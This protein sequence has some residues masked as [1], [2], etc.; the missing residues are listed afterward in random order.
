MPPVRS[1]INQ[2]PGV[3]AHLHSYWQGERGWNNFHNPHIAQL[4]AAL[5]ARLLPM[6]Y[7]FEVED[8]LQVRRADEYTCHPKSDLTIYDLDPARSGQLSRQSADLTGLVLPLVIVL[9]RNPISEKPYRALSVSKRGDSKP[10]AWIELLSPSNK[11]PGDDA[12][13]Y[14]RKRHDLLDG[15]IVFVE[16]DYLHAP[17]DADPDSPV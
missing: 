5:K 6:G 7:T 1:V 2:Y 14:V 12:D 13:T 17:P 4:T 8:S 15:G 9:E 10:V 3:N 16:I 11:R